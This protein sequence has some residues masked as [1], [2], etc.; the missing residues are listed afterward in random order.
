MQ[1]E[2]KKGKSDTCDGEVEVEDPSPGSLL[3][4]DT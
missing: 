4:N 3:D 1:E 2:E